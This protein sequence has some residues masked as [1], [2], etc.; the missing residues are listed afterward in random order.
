MAAGVT[1]KMKRKAGWFASGDL[2]AGEFGL[3][4]TNQV[5]AM[6]SDGSNILI[7]SPMISVGFGYHTTNS[8]A[9]LRLQTPGGIGKASNNEGWK[10]PFDLWCVGMC[11]NVDVNAS[12][13]VDAGAAAGCACTE[14][15]AAAAVGTVA[16]AAEVAPDRA[17]IAA[18]SALAMTA[19]TGSMVLGATVAAVGAPGAAAPI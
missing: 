7:M 8:G 5:L 15:V 12:G 4:T 6:S 13:A 16:A 11:W 17:V 9:I 10:P 19:A 14:R 2:A 18:S 1:L 3:D